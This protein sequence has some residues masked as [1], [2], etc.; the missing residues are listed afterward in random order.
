VTRTPYAIGLY[1][2][3]QISGLNTKRNFHQ[4]LAASRWI[5]RAEV[6]CTDFLPYLSEPRPPTHDPTT[7]PAKTTLVTR[8]SS[9]T[10]TPHSA[11]TDGPTKDSSMAS[12]ASATLPVPINTSRRAWNRPKP[13]RDNASS[14]VYA[15]SEP[16]AMPTGARGGMPRQG[17]VDRGDCDRRRGKQSFVCQRLTNQR[18]AKPNERPSASSYITKYM[19]AREENERNSH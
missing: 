12:M 5:N 3:S 17:A 14:T 6:N 1:F 10:E 4:L 15:S 18:Y 13:R 11:L 2:F 9:A 19:R 16:L 7:V 8:P